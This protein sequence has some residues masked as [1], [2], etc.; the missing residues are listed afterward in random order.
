MNFYK[1]WRARLA[2]NTVVGIALPRLNSISTAAAKIT[3]LHLSLVKM[4]RPEMTDA[5]PLIPAYS[6]PNT[7]LARFRAFLEEG[8]LR[9]H[10]LNGCSKPTSS[11]LGRLL[12]LRRLGLKI[13]RIHPVAGLCNSSP[14]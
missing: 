4:T 12:A 3:A 10:L 7:F 9:S 2:E 8:D 1:M 11:P 14:R 6:P 13:P 5:S